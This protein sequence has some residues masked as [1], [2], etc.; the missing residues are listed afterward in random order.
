LVI[1]FCIGYLLGGRF[2]IRTPLD[3][4]VLL[5]LILLPVTLLVTPDR[6]LTLSHIYKM[7]SSIALFYAI[8]GFFEEKPWFKLGALGIG[9]VGMGL[10][11]LIFLGT[12]WTLT[13]TSWLP[14]D[15]YQLLPGRIRPFWNPEGFNSNI[16]G[17]TLAM[18]LP[19]PLAYL[20]FSHR[21]HVRWAG[22]FGSVVIGLV[23]LLTQSR[24]AIS[25][26]L[27][28]IAVMLVVHKRRWLV[29]GVALIIVGILSFQFVGTDAVPGS[30][31]SLAV[32]S[33]VQSAQGRMELWSR[34]LMM[35][36]DFS[37][38]GIGFGTVVKVMPLMYPTFVVPND[39]GIEHV[40]NLYL[41]AGVDLGFP[42]LIAKLAFLL[43]LLY[44]A[45]RGARSAQGDPLEPVALAMLGMI[46]IFA[47][48]GFT[49]DFT[50]YAKAHLI[51]WGL[52][53]FALAVGMHLVRTQTV[54]A[55]E[56][57]PDA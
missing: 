41:Q 11:I 13:K 28:G 55:A 19:V 53:G 47:V 26:L 20:L 3:I 38:T 23:L 9:T 17:G 42:G 6:T 8:V 2:V 25:A 43:G 40:H 48:H 12:R 1:V 14:V 18:I 7:I 51:A 34:G 56:S 49:D 4:P 45:W 54:P 33:A 52:F 44:I 27:A 10:A 21:W 22:L 24:G 5:L 29:A 37:F 46:V 57:A 39:A 30:D 32:Q 36:Q 31:S 16:A 50:F 35:L 15:P